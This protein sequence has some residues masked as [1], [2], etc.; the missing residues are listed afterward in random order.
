MWEADAEGRQMAVGNGA[1]Q[2][3]LNA[4]NTSVAGLLAVEGPLTGVDAAGSLGFADGISEGS[5][6]RIGR[7]GQGG[8]RWECWCFDCTRHCT[9]PIVMVMHMA[10]HFV[11][12][13]GNGDVRSQGPRAVP[14]K[15]TEASAARRFHKC[16]VASSWTAGAFHETLSCWPRVRAA[17]VSCL[18]GAL[19]YAAARFAG[20]A[21]RAGLC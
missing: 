4:L 9:P 3:A 21:P 1:D 2:L 6:G 8:C 14:G 18:G 16:K 12:A 13:M 19:F 15:H 10:P 11:I 20:Q 7:Q 17:S 5:C